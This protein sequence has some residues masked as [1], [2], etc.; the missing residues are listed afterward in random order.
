MSVLCPRACQLCTPAPG[1]RA[2]RAG[3]AT[4]TCACR[5]LSMEEGP[6]GVPWAQGCQDMCLEW[7]HS[8][9][10][11]RGA[12]HLLFYR[13]LPWAGQGWVGRW[14]LPPR[15]NVR[16]IVWPHAPLTRP[17]HL[18]IA[19]F[20][21]RPAAAA[22]AEPEL[23]PTAGGEPLVKINIAGAYGHGRGGGMCPW[24]GDGDAY[25]RPAAP[26]CRAGQLAA[27]A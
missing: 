8:P 10:E 19:P 26:N 21:L 13:L 24:G 1:E 4:L 20:A 6:G 16:T 17:S 2:Q 23:P 15:R 7:L 22:A 11:L 9:V 5:A 18:F 25:D 3:R 14:M 12:R 27:A